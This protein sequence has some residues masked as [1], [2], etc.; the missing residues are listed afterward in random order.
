MSHGFTYMLLLLS[1][2]Y[3]KWTSLYIDTVIAKVSDI[4]ALFYPSSEE[5]ILLIFH[6]HSAFSLAIRAKV[7]VELEAATAVAVAA[8]VVT[9]MQ[10]NQGPENRLNIELNFNSCEIN[11]KRCCLFKISFQ[12]HHRI[13]ML[14]L[15]FLVG[16]FYSVRHMIKS[17]RFP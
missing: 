6:F 8:A 9:I 5:K 3:R 15:L 12:S 7:K 11:P 4:N 16:V 10:K 17:F 2:C 14:S 13:K 1:F